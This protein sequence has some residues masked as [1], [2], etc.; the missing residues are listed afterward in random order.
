M[1]SKPFY[2]LYMCIFYYGY[3]WQFLVNIEGGGG[4]T[5]LVD[6]LHLIIVS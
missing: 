2:P 5:P 1:V 3:F 6:W 4:V